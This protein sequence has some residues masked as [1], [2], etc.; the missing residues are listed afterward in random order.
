MGATEK[1]T[2][3]VYEGEK[4]IPATTRQSAAHDAIRRN[5]AKKEKKRAQFLRVQRRL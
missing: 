5:K 4:K 3:E 1:E 2:G